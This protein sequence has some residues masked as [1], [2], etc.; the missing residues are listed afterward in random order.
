MSDDL[1][2]PLTDNEPEESGSDAGAP[3]LFS[4]FVNGQLD[5]SSLAKPDVNLPRFSLPVREDD[6]EDED[7]DLHFNLFE[8]DS[9]DTQPVNDTPPARPAFGGLPSRPGSVFGNSKGTSL[10]GSLGLPSSKTM[11]TAKDPRWRH[12]VYTV[13]NDLEIHHLPQFPRP[14]RVSVIHNAGRRL[15]RRIDYIRNIQPGRTAV[16]LSLGLSRPPLIGTIDD[17]TVSIKAA[18]SSLTYLVMGWEW[19]LDRL[20]SMGAVTIFLMMLVIATIAI[21]FFL[22]ALPSDMRTAINGLFEPNI[23]RIETEMAVQQG[24]IE[25]L[26]QA[27]HVLSEPDMPSRALLHDGG[28]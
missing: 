3:N 28:R 13:S 15:N 26:E 9:E 20:I 6:E 4:D 24:R 18:G 14:A 17:D 27:L 11:P 7:D 1:V 25:A 10:F 19:L 2:P 8:L 22:N 5:L 16:K 21:G 12:G 23:V